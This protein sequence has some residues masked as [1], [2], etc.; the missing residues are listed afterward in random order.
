[1]Q[2]SFVIKLLLILI[3]IRENLGIIGGLPVWHYPFFVRIQSQSKECG[4]TLIAEDAVLTSAN[5]LVNDLWERYCFPREIVVYTN[6]L[7]S[8]STPPPISF[9]TF[10]KNIITK[11]LECK[12]ET[13]NFKITSRVTVKYL[14]TGFVYT[15]F[16]YEGTHS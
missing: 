10:V 13:S 1:M 7:F 4:G 6:R 14:D 15:V 16:A 8:V 5:C 12:P 3:K 11:R 2:A 9:G